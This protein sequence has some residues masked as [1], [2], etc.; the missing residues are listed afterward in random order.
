[1]RGLIFVY[2]HRLHRHFYSKI[3]TYTLSKNET[4]VLKMF[5]QCKYVIVYV[6][7]TTI[8]STTIQSD[9]QGFQ[10]GYDLMFCVSFVYIQFTISTFL[11]G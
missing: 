4:I 6:T 3:S 8:A 11:V 1:M 5:K 2:D 10:N 9:S 7:L